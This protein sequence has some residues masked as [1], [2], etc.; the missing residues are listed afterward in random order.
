LFLLCMSVI[1]LV[2]TVPVIIVAFMRVEGREPW[3]LSLIVAACV[4]ALIYGVFEKI[5]HIPWP[6]S[7][8]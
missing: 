1:G 5:I 8:L 4:T 7:L 6:S 3:R 2:P